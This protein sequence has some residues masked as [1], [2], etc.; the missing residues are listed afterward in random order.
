MPQLTER[1]AAQVSEKIYGVSH[2]NRISR[3]DVITK[4]DAMTF[5]ASEEVQRDAHNLAQQTE[6][7]MDVD[8][9]AV[10]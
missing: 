2:S 7:A 1:A 8:A 9:G 5:L 10:E 3:V 4:E 6:M